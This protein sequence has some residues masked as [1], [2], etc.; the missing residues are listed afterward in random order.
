MF[1]LLRFWR[2]TVSLARRADILDPVGHYWRGLAPVHSDAWVFAGMREEDRVEVA[3]ACWQLG[4]FDRFGMIECIHPK[5]PV[6]HDGLDHCVLEYLCDVIGSYILV[7]P[8]FP[9]VG[10][11]ETA[12]VNDVHNF[13]ETVLARVADFRSTSG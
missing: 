10:R 12:L 7:P 3:S 8:G 4:R 13:V 1:F 2:E 11:S 6:R 5:R 9:V